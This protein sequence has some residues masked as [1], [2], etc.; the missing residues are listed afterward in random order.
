[1]APISPRTHDQPSA[2][3]GAT[4]ANEG[5]HLSVWAPEARELQVVMENSCSH[6]LPLSGDG[7][8]QGIPPARAGDRYKFLVDGK[9]PFPD[10]ASRY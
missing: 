3:L 1:M 9:G 8:F 2:R 7:Y 4:P 6:H 5:I 10:P